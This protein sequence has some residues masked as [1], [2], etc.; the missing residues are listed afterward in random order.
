MLTSWLR[1]GFLITAILLGGCQSAFLTLPGARLTG[2]EQHVDSFRFARD[3]RLLRLEVR[4]EHPYSVWLRVVMRDDDL[5]IDAAPHRRWYRYLKENPH[6]R[7]QLGPKVYPA[8]AMPVTDPALISTFIRGR[9]VYR[10]I[11]E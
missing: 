11:P 7:V 8:L 9:N 6:I 3:Y 1:C 10:L 4:P 2:E 5:Y